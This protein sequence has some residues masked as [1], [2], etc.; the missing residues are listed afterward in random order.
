MRYGDMLRNRFQ[1]VE[2]QTRTTAKRR[3]SSNDETSSEQLLGHP[4]RGS[5]DAGLHDDCCLPVAYQT[6]SY[7][8]AAQSQCRRR[9]TELL[10]TP[11]V[12]YAV[13][14]LY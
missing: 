14:R 11:V 12:T 4:E 9:G 13:A 6:G 7:N 1:H 3:R 5:A 8:G 10:N 2:S